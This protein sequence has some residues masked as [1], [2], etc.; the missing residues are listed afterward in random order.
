MVEARVFF[1]LDSLQIPSGYTPGLYDIVDV[2]AV[3]SI[4]QHCSLRAVSVT[5]VEV[6]I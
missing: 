6:E 4:Q 1:T 2:V 5:P 3:D